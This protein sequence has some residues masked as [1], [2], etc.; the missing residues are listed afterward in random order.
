MGI[1][2][3]DI[4]SPAS[5]FPTPSSVDSSAITSDVSS[6]VPELSMANNSS[7]SIEG[8]VLACGSSVTVGTLH[9]LDNSTD[10]RMGMAVPKTMSPNPACARSCKSLEA[11]ST[12][13]TFSPSSSSS[14]I[15]SSSSLPLSSICVSI[16]ITSS[17]SVPR[18][19]NASASSKEPSSCL[20]RFSGSMGSFSSKTSSPYSASPS[21]CSGATDGVAAGPPS[22]AMLWDAAKYCILCWEARSAACAIARSRCSAS[23]AV[24]GLLLAVVGLLFEGSSSSSSSS[25]W[26]SE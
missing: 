14:S 5:K 23:T 7:S 11:G 17:S 2:D 22:Y 6:L 3:P 12:L 24:P 20:L 15:I 19:S 21:P 8:L 9:K 1:D 25:S 4:M 13:S 26:I 16:A 18:F 10:S